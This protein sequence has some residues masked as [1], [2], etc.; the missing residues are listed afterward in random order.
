MKLFLNLFVQWV[1]FT[2]LW[3]VFVFQLT[4]IEVF[5]GAAAS[6]VTVFALQIALRSERL[7]FQ[8]RLRW[9]A[10]AWRLPRMIA[11]DLW[12]VLKAL[13]RLVVRAPSQG[14]FQLGG[15]TAAA[16]DCR[17]SAQRALTILYVSASPNS[18]IIDIDREKANLLI[19]QLEAAPIPKVVRE[20][21]E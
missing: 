16:E 13:A 12:V 18:V 9:L 8:P 21:E 11:V 1:A 17:A 7:C 6:A 2:L 5:A 10:Q 20:L 19:H 14:L 3:L 15:F 4:A